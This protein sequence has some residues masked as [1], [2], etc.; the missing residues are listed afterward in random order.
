MTVVPI[1]KESS[2]DMTP[3]I[4]FTIPDEIAEQMNRSTF[5][6]WLAEYTRQQREEAYDEGVGVG[7]FYAEDMTF[8]PLSPYRYRKE[9][10]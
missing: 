3:K 10:S 2:E 1:I 8:A 9:T 7:Q 6:R 5:D 4:S